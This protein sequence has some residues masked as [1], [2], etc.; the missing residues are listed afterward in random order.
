MCSCVYTNTLG[1][2]RTA[3]RAVAGDFIKEFIAHG[4]G[5]VRLLSKP[6]KK[7]NV[8]HAAHLRSKAVKYLAVGKISTVIMTKFKTG[9]VLTAFPLMGVS[10]LRDHV[11]TI[12]AIKVSLS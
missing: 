6:C 11:D 9:A 3:C 5:W 1:G 4:L 7:K 2:K 8:W 10:V 12:P